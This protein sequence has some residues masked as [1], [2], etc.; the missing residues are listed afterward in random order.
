M[1]VTSR[2][3][4]LVLAATV[5]ALGLVP[6]SASSPEA[7][8]ADA[9]QIAVGYLSQ[10]ATE[11]GVGSADVAEL[12]VTSKYRSRNSGLTHVNLNQRYQGLEVF[13]GH[14]TVN[15]APDG[16]V[17][18]VGGD[19]V[20]G[21]KAATAA[22]PAVGAVAAVEAAADALEL[23]EPDDLRVLSSRGGRAQETVVSNGG[24]S[25]AAIPARLGWQP[26]ASGLR[27]AWQL[28]IDAASE[29]HL[30]N[31]TVDANSAKLLDA[32]DWTVH[33]DLGTLAT[34]LSRPSAGQAAAS[35]GTPDPVD[36]GS[37]Y[38]VLA[39]PTE[40]PN[41][42]DRTLLTN[43]ADALASP[44]GWHDTNGADGPEL[45]ITRGNNAHAYLDQE[46]DEAPDFGDTDGG[47]G[48]DF[49]FP[50]DLTEHAQHY[51]DAVVTNLFY[52][53][54]AFHDIY[55]RYGF[56]EA[57]GNFQANNYGRGGLEGDY[58]RCEAADGSGTNNA[59]FSTP[60]EPTT[61]GAVPRMQM[62]LWPGNALGRQNEVLVNGTTSIGAGWARFGPPAT[63]AGVTGA[64][65]LV[66][67]G[68]ATPPVGTVNDGCEP[69]T[70][71][72][73]SI[74]L[75]DRASS[76]PAP[77]PPAPPLPPTCTFL[78]QVQNAYNAGA[79]AVI[80]ANNTSGNAPIINGPTSNPTPPIPTVSLTQEN[81]TALKALL[82]ASGTIRK[83]PSHPGIRDGDFENG[84]IIHEYTH[85]V[86]NRLT[87]GPAVNCLTGNEQA[88]EGWS[89]W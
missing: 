72:A 59:N 46:D 36:D 23:D 66:N 29:E 83:H 63:N 69:Y 22:T 8:N 57:S 33:D 67:D 34:T 13:G 52:G 88:G 74:A 53:C 4:F 68:A 20:D 78:Q 37:S 26:T 27:L 48:L 65:V 89:D 5:L 50:A 62:F 17:V 32:D 76:P 12:A 28:V 47:A 42:A 80:I 60:T 84:I 31:A 41:D 44:F 77:P 10:N 86:S 6:G 51:R 71:P 64:I 21:L 38:R 40:S 14:V 39:V 49:D 35:A 56:D 54:N 55:Y 1:P 7:G 19:L 82:P 61:T 43:P 2:G 18:F 25:A 85:G 15:V 79:S 45:T 30:W 73:N 16:A 3:P 81:G 75:V 9:Y 11:L 24:I 70:L 87:G 58:V